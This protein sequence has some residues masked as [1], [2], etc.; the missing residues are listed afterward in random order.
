MSISNSQLQDYL[1]YVRQMT[2]DQIKA[3]AR[4]LYA[5]AQTQTKRELMNELPHE[6]RVALVS[7]WVK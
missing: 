3:V 4:E 6:D 7:I 1:P 2:Q 5:H